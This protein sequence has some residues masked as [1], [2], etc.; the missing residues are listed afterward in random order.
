MPE[1]RKPFVV[2]LDGPAGAGKSTIARCLAQT[3]GFTLLDTGAI[4]RTVAL[5]A[6]RAGIGFDDEPRLV[7]LALDL[8]THRRLVLEP[9]LRSGMCVLLDGQ[10]LGEELRTPRI[11]MGASIVSA[12]GG[13]RLALLDLQRSF[14]SGTPGLVAEGRDI[15]TVIFPGADVKIF[16]TASVADRASR[17]FPEFRAKD[18]TYTLART[19]DSVVA[20]D[21][22]DESRLVAPLRRADDA[23]VVDSTGKGAET[24][25]H[26]VIEIV[27]RARERVR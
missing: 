19:R 27:R 11:S 20:R 21:A 16:L 26:E 24:T 6:E 3:F 1:T 22:Q 14:A 18:P 15:G 17:R 23:I 8:M 10:S 4:Y 7:A 2:A 5:A 9:T 25:M 12:I 13:V